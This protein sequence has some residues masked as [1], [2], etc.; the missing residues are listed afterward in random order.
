MGITKFFSR[1]EAAG[2]TR[3]VD[4]I[5]WRGDDFH[6]SAVIDG[7]SFAFHIFRTCNKS[8]DERSEDIIGSSVSYTDCAAAAVTFLETLEDHGIIIDSVFFD[9]ALPAWKRQTRRERLQNFARSLD[10]YRKQQDKQTKSQLASVEPLQSGL[11]PPF[12]VQAVQEAI[13]DSR[14][15]DLVYS[16]P[17]E[18]DEYCVTAAKKANLT[19]VEKK[20]AIFTSDSDLAVYESGRQTHIMLFDDYY[21]I[22][23][24]ALGSVIKA[25]T[26]WPSAIA[27][28]IWRDNLHEL[29]YY[30]AAYKDQSVARL[31]AT[32]IGP[33]KSPPVDEY[34]SFTEHF[35]AKVAD[36][37]S[38]LQGDEAE[39]QSLLGLDA[40]VAELVHQAKTK[41]GLASPDEFEIFLPFV[42]EDSSKRSAWRVGSGIRQAAYTILLKHLDC[43][44][45]Q[46]REFKRSGVAS[47]SL[48][49]SGMDDSALQMG[50][51]ALYEYFDEDTRRAASGDES[52]VESWRTV[53]VRLMLADMDD[54]PQPAELVDLIDGTLCTDWQMVHLSAHYQT[55]FYSV[56]LLHQVMRYCHRDGR[57]PKL[58]VRL[59][60]M[61]GIAAFFEPDESIAGT[62]AEDEWC[63]FFEEHLATM[64]T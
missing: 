27:R 6:T 56:R 58:L 19:H 8:I 42:I 41:T 40:R 2:Y 14:F 37:L 15:K 18:A 47:G 7:P 13:L 10:T 44:A 17:G 43:S 53:I 1:M 9:G 4:N 23:P 24:D 57:K 28:K 35:T 16:V 29:A 11:V 3:I 63:R 39:R 25:T 26:L 52:A 21:Q 62:D 45:T 60:G 30:M 51:D 54:L 33:G 34:R 50:L 12:L 31:I 5:G 32:K 38:L 48:K 64:N 20:V 49:V 59:D 46:I 61:P 22:Q 36:S 55:T